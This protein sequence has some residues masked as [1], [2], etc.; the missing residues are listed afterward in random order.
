MT[1]PAFGSQGSDHPTSEVPDAFWLFE[2]FD[3]VVAVRDTNPDP[4]FKCLAAKRV[5]F[6]PD[7]PSATYRWS[8]NVD[9]DEEKKY[10][11]IH[12]TAGPTP[13]AVNAVV[14]SDT[15]HPDTQRFLYTDYETCGILETHYFGNQCILWVPTDLRDSFPEEC[16]KK[17]TE[18]CGEGVSL[19]DKNLCGGTQA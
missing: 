15:G 17:H 7:V 5:A 13:D 6:D 2:H 19:Y 12:Y 10:P 16:L 9:G 3:D 1:V 4:M 18:I 14:N 8:L 11:L